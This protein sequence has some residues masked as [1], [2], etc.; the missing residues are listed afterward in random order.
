VE[1]AMDD[2]EVEDDTE[3]CDIERERALYTDEPVE[4][5][6]LVREW[7]EMPPPTGDW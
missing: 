1:G 2:A 4:A 6:E 7:R 5:S 3:S